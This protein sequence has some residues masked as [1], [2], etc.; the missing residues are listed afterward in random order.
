VARAADFDLAKALAEK[1]FTPAVRD[2]DAIVALLATLDEATLGK[3][4]AALAGLGEPA[5]VAIEK[6]LPAVADE[7]ARAKTIQALGL[8]ARRGDAG[9]RDRLLVTLGD[10]SSRVRRAAISALANLE[11][12][13]DVRAAL[14]VRWDDPTAPADERRALAE[15]FGKLGGDELVSRLRALDPQ[16][17]AELARRRDRGLL[18]ADR[19]AKRGTES[20]VRT[21][22]APPSPLAVV[23]HTKPGLAGLLV[24]ELRSLNIEARADRDDTAYTTLDA[25]WATLY[26]SRLWASAGIRVPRP[27]GDSG[28]ALV[29][30]IVAGLTAAPV[31]T[32]LAAWTTGPIRWR[33]ELPEGKQRAVV[34]RVARDVTTYAPELVND[35][36]ATT[37]DVRIADATALELIPRRA[38]DPRFAY[39]VADVPAASHPAVAAALARVG[40]PHDRDRVWDPFCGSGMELIECGRLAKCDLFGTDLDDRA[41]DAANQNATAAGLNIAFTLGDARAALGD[42][43]L[44][45]I[46]SNPPLGSRVAVDAPGLLNAL[47]PVIARRLSPKGRFVWL[48]PNTRATSPLAEQLRF[49]RTFSA[50]V[51]L[52]GVR[53]RLERWHR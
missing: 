22:V 35:P 42:G 41:L 26:K 48:T 44:D 9:A 5:R 19:G 4:Q 52:G 18:V 39:R 34:W 46:I 16:H 1:N 7:G 31:R 20:E 10:S 12:A 21:D 24:D 8:I 53:G 50:N 37:W 17:D 15:A 45:L 36:T 13:D 11:A 38:A 3:A 23:L 30:S 28:D 2:V 32:L 51:D 47:L 43:D 29:N 6:A 14:V 25:P 40:E 49:R 33:V 27:A